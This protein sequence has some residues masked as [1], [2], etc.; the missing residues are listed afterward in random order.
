MQVFCIMAVNV[1]VV[2][3]VVVVPLRITVYSFLHSVISGNIW[4]ENHQQSLCK[5][6]YIC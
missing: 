5:C 4:R 1:V 6:Y 3:V 2:V